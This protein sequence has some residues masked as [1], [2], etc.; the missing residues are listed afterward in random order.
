[1]VGGTVILLVLVADVTG[2]FASCFSRS[3]STIVPS[4]EQRDLCGNEKCRAVLRPPL[5]QCSDCKRV[6]YCSRECQAKAWEDG[7]QNECQP[8]APLS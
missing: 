1:M 8:A 5:L 7:H 4:Q 2:V 3:R 6:V